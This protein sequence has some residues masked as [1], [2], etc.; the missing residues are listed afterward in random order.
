MRG[1]VIEL[2]PG[3]RQQD[4]DAVDPYPNAYRRQAIR[5]Q[6]LSLLA[7]MVEADDLG[8]REEVANAI[9]WQLR[10]LNRCVLESFRQLAR[11]SEVS[12]QTT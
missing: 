3:I 5:D 6:M 2:K 9:Y 10:D 4:D 1:E 7:D 8:Q 12:R 11:N